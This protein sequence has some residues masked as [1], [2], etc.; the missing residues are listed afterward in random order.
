MRKSQAPVL[1]SG[2]GLLLL[3]LTQGRAGPGDLWGLG[4]LPGER[5]LNSSTTRHRLA[6][7]EA[8]PLQPGAF[9]PPTSTHSCDL[10]TLPVSLHPLIPPSRVQGS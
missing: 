4:A 9:S 7:S 10:S 3:H 8:P 1:A 6:G 2:S 5:V